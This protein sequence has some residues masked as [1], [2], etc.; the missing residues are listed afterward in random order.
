MSDGAWT[1]VLIVFV[2]MFLIQA[3]QFVWIEYLLNRIDV[4]EDGGREAE[5]LN[6]ACPSLPGAARSPRTHGRVPVS[7]RRGPQLVADTPHVDDPARQPGRGEL[8]AHA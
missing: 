7:P 5:L 8:A 1:V 4:L 6:V 3:A 2:T